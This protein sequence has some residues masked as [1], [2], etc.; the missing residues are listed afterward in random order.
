[1]KRGREVGG[2]HAAIRPRRRNLAPRRADHPPPRRRT[3]GSRGRRRNLAPRRADH[4]CG[5]PTALASPGAGR[6]PVARAGAGVRVGRARRQ[7]VPEETKSDGPKP[8]QT[9]ADQTG[10]GTAFGVD[11]GGSGIK[12]AVV[13]LRTGLLLTERRK[14]LTP[15]PS[16]ID[17]VADVVTRLVGEAG[18]TGLVGA[19]FPAVIKHGV[20]LT[21]ANVD[22]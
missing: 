3:Q 22:K 2:W 13:E 11:I 4:R 5:G 20:A 1:G 9:G 15:R 19:T 6:R 12:G 17:A 16:T 21:A 7:R 8:D 10:A 14:F 18:W